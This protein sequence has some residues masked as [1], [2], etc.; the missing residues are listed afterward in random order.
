MQ[1]NKEKYLSEFWSFYNPP[2]S[3]E[4][5][6][7]WLNNADTS[8]AFY[9]AF[10]PLYY[11]I[12]TDASDINIQNLRVLADHKGWIVGDPHPAN[13]GAIL[14]NNLSLKQS[15]IYTANDPDDGIGPCPLYLDLLRFLT[16]V[17]IIEN[18]CTPVNKIK[19]AYLQGLKDELLLEQPREI[20]QCLKRLWKNEKEL[21]K[22]DYQRFFEDRK[23]KVDLSTVEILDQELM[24]LNTLLK[25][26]WQDQKFKIDQGFK[27]TRAKGG[28]GGLQ[29]KVLLVKFSKRKHPTR[30]SRS[31]WLVIELKG[32]R[33]PSSQYDS[34]LSADAVKEA[35]LETMQWQSRNSLSK[36]Y[37]IVKDSHNSTI[38]STIRD[39]Q[40]QYWT[41]RPRWVE[42]PIVDPNEVKQNKQRQKIYLYQ[43][44][45][46]GNLHRI[47]ATNPNVYHDEV[48]QTKAKLWK[49]SAKYMANELENIRESICPRSHAPAW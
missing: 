44:N 18:G 21:K 23:N 28:S 36:L 20:K 25:N 9:R 2:I 1:N 31:K 38:E 34:N 32:I 43:A 46:L 22:R 49:N 17:H 7:L 35:Q 16:G 42:N 15:V 33:K 10:V 48:K 14:T 3:N 6:S 26:L 13:F 12:L 47:K 40:G 45:V 29:R 5:K 11:R 4:I 30:I 41:V 37:R 19:K 27:Y 39:K 24:S 8:Y